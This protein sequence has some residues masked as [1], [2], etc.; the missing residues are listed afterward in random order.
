MAHLGSAWTAP[1]WLTHPLPRLVEFHPAWL[2]G[3]VWKGRTLFRGECLLKT[4]STSLLCLYRYGYVFVL[5]SLFL[6]RSLAVLPR[7]ECGGMISAHCNLSPLGSS[8]SSASASWAAE[9]IGR[10]HHAQ[11]IFVFSVETGFLL[12]GQAGLEHLTSW[13]TCLSLPKCWDY[14]LEPPRPASNFS[15]L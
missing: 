10:H 1:A 2:R 15:F 6:R 5:L 13:S 7:L 11:L 8:D 14:R 12:I 9:T 3:T 4:P